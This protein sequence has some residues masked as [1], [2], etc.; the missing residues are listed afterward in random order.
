M[1]P[2]LF[3]TVITQ[4]DGVLRGP[5]RR[6]RQMLSDQDYA[7]HASIHDDATARQLGF[8][9]GTIEGP[10]HFSQF[11][12]LACAVWGDGW[13]AKGCI[14]VH[15]RAPSFDGEEVIAWLRRPVSGERQ[16]EIWMTK[17]DGT[18]IL[19]GTA[20]I[21]PSVTQTALEMRM[22]QLKPLQD[23]VILRDVEIGAQVPRVPVRMD[24]DARMEPLYPFSLSDKLQ[25]IT[26]ASPA[27][28]QDDNPWQ[29][30]IVP[31]EMISVLMQRTWD[32]V[33]VG[34]RGPAVGLFADQEI[35]LLDGP[36]Y[37]GLPY[38]V[39]REVIF[40][41]GSRRTESLW[42]RTTLYE[43]GGVK[44]IAHML[45]NSAIMKESYAGYEAER[46]ALYGP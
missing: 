29:R 39:E 22:A 4:E 6:P 26:E 8:Q 12:P 36:V 42:V 46:Q 3:E 31:M 13:L 2:A 45:I 15:Y 34:V 41:S 37:V 43:A 24:P 20:S 32:E 25:V 23:A 17:A 33:Q 16:A 19:R 18:E 38:E 10:T 7:G 1:P 30:R 44:P 27:Y 21:E 28:A 11:A 14:S 40:L 35:R 5:A 9:G